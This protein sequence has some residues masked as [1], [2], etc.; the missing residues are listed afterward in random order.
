MYKILHIPTSL[1]IS[2]WSLSSRDFFYIET[3]LKDLPYA[4]EN[5]GVFTE[6][7]FNTSLEA[8]NALDSYIKSIHLFMKSLSFENENALHVTEIYTNKIYFDIIE[9]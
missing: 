7:I 2:T 6:C 9:I 1:F 4:C 8:E 3:E 5:Y